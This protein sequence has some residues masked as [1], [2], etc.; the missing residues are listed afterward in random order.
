MLRSLIPIYGAKILT[1]I[2]TGMGQ[3]GMRGAQDVVKAGGRVIAQD[4]ETSVV[5]GMPGAVALAGLCS[6]VLPLPEI[7]AAVRKATMRV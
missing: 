7:G 4:E 5:W 3:D 2:L 6:A 1:V